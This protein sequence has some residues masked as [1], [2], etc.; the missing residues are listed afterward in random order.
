MRFAGLPLAGLVKGGVFKLIE[1]AEELEGASVLDD[2]VG[3]LAM[4]RR[5]WSKTDANEIK[6]KL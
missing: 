6:E 4:L 5:I 1:F 3:G 2:S